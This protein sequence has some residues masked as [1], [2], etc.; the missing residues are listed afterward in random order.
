MARG[1]Y[2]TSSDIMG[3]LTAA[4]YDP[5]MALVENK[6]N[7]E[8]PHFDPDV[9]A[10]EDSPE[11]LARLLSGV[12]GLP[13][14]FLGQLSAEIPHVKGTETG[15]RMLLS[16]LANGGRFYEGWRVKEIRDKGAS[17]T[18]EEAGYLAGFDE[19]FNSAPVG[20]DEGRNL[21]VHV[22]E[23]S[24]RLSSVPRDDQQETV[25]EWINEFVAESVIVV[26]SADPNKVSTDASPGV[27]M[28][29]EI[30]TTLP[31]TDVGMDIQMAE[32]RVSTDAGLD[33][34]VKEVV[35]YSGTHEY[36]GEARYSGDGDE[37]VGD[38]S[39]KL[40]MTSGPA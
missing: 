21:Y 11:G 16:L 28:K 30:E 34:D 40:T 29:T 17:R 36:D 38:V 19:D 18:S 33:M 2:E 31:S 35:L 6:W 7:T 22:N 37:D 5:A 27:E 14:S 8:S 26:F 39:I 23:Y 32:T 4:F 15:F 12:S 24:D 13:K 20:A 25:E 3:F 1:L 10:R 9:I